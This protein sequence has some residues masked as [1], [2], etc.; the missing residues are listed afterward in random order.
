MKLQAANLQITLTMVFIFILGMI[1]I[2]STT[3]A[4]D[5]LFKGNS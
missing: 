4:Q 1:L 2:N 5:K 3:A